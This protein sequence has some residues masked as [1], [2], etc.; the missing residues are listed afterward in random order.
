[1]MP[2]WIVETITTPTPAVVGVTGGTPTVIATEHKLVEPTPAELVIT[3][4]QPLSGPVAIPSAATL[5]IIGGTPTITQA[6]N[7]TPGSV[8]LTITGGQPAVTQ[9]TQLTPTTTT[10]TITGG[11]PTVTTKAPAAYQTIG[12]G[13]VA[14]GNPSINFTATTGAD[15]FAIVNWDRSG[16][17]ISAITYGGVAMTLIAS[18]PHNNT[19]ANGALSIYGLAGAGTGAAKSLAITSAGTA[20]YYLNAI[21]FTNVGTVGTPVTTYGT[22]TVATQSVTVPS[23]GIVLQAVSAGSGGGSVGDFTSFSGVT[24]RWHAASSATSLA[25]NTTTTSGST[26][27]TAAVNQA[28][29]IIN[30]PLT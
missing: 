22:G 30:V 29:A 23:N 3:G 1:M 6:R 25:I 21:S 12:T 20:W 24:N 10:L 11:T 13:V 17:G 14:A 18:I 26:S 2:G 7:L 15:V 27:S 9:H 28:W 16:G 19:T 4:G 5:S 8:N